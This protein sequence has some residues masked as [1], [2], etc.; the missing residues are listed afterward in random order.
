MPVDPKT[1]AMKKKIIICDDELPI[2]DVLTLALS[3]DIH[4]I[5]PTS[6]STELK[7]I[8]EDTEPDLLIVDLQMP[9]V[10]GDDIVREIKSS[11]R[12]GHIKVL[13]I[14]ASLSG[15]EIAD[16]CGA[17]AFLAKPFD[18]DELEDLVKNLTN[19]G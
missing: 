5:I 17:D 8:I 11:D 7:A 9:F 3:N 19:L 13:M 15:R 4:E 2:L 6:K 16:N 12:H 14:S 18:L 1:I 10:K